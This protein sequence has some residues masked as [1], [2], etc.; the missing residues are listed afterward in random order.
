MQ[1]KFIYKKKGHTYIVDFD[2]QKTVDLPEFEQYYRLRES[3]PK[4]APKKWFKKFGEDMC[5]H[6]EIAYS[7]LSEL[8]N[9]EL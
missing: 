8:E 4:V 1:T 9:E 2:L 3:N 6:L 5:Q 7:V